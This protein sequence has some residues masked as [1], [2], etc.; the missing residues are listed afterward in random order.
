M[1]SNLGDR[2]LFLQRAVNQ[3]AATVRWSAVSAVYETA[4]M[5]VLD[6]PAFLNAAARG[7]TNLGPLQLLAELKDLEARLGRQTRARFGPREIDLDLIAYQGMQMESPE[8]TL[9]HPRIAERRFVL[10]PICDIA[11]NWPIGDREAQD[12]LHETESQRDSVITFADAVLSLPS[13]K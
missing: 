9:P 11:P 13:P 3:L 10:L 2:F 4:P 12:L 6:Q 8:L 7:E 1:G 5:Y